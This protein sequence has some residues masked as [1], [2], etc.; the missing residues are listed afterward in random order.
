MSAPVAAQDYRFAGSDAPRGATAT[1]N[2]RVPL[3]VDRARARPSYGL[4][5]SYGQS[6]ATPAMDGREMTRAMNVADFRF[7][8]TRLRHARVASFDLANLDRDRRMN[9]VGG[10]KKSLLII[11]AIV[12]GGILIC[13]AADCFDGDDESS[14]STSN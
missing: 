3:G 4:T 5:L 7:T 8:G 10:G 13:V 2:L 6:F 12:V 14:S 1:V 9:L 11:G